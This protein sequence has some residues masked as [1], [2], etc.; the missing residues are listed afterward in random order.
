MILNI[1]LRTLKSCMVPVSYTHLDVYKRQLQYDLRCQKC[2]TLFECLHCRVYPFVCGAFIRS[3]GSPMPVF[4]SDV[5]S[6]EPKFQSRT[7]TLAQSLPYKILVES[8]S[9]FVINNNNIII[10]VLLPL[11]R[12][13][14]VDCPDWAVWYR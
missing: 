12:Y 8:L 4:H 9:L 3:Q 7:I 6:L 13:R 14:W 11:K 1:N 2:S 10:I 5:S